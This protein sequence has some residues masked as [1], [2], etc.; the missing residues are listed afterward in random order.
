[1]LC[2]TLFHNRSQHTP[3]LLL[4]QLAAFVLLHTAEACVCVRRVRLDGAAIGD[5]SPELVALV[6]Q[7]LQQRAVQPV[8]LLV[9]LHG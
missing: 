8:L 5:D 7:T 1:M 9:S 2:H 4:Q 6:A 3:G